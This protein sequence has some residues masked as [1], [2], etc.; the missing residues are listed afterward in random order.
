MDEDRKVIFLSLLREVINFPSLIIQNPVGHYK[1]D[2]LK[3]TPK[4]G[5]N[6]VFNEKSGQW[7]KLLIWNP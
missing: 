1:N 4:D 3:M 2:N 5:A 6:I 7:I